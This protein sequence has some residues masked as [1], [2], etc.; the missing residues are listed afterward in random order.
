MPDGPSTGD[1]PLAGR[2]PASPTAV[3]T[4]AALLVALS[5]VLLGNADGLHAWFA[6]DDFLWLELSSL[7]SV[8]RSFV[9]PWGHGPA[10]RP[11]SRV[12][13]YA[14]Y[15][16]FGLDAGPWHL[17]SLLWHAAATTLLA[18]LLARTTGDAR[19][20]LVAA[21]IFAVLPLHY[22]NT[23]WISAR[24]HPIALM[25]SLGSLLAVESHLRSG[26]RRSLATAAALLALALLTYEAPI[27]TLPLALLVVSVRLRSGAHG[28]VWRRAALAL[29]VLATVVVLYLAARHRVLAGANLYAA[30]LTRSDAFTRFGARYV[31]AG[32]QMLDQ[33]WPSPW[34]FAAAGVV[35]CLVRRR[36]IP[37]ALAGGVVIAFGYAPFSPVENVAPRFLYAA[38]AGLAMVLAAAIAGLA[39]LPRI[40]RA[41]AALLFALLLVHE[42]RATRQIAR[43]FRDAGDLGRRTLARLA[44]AWPAPDPDRP[45]VVLGVPTGLGHAMI[46]FTYF[47]LALGTFHPAHAGMRVPGHVLTDFPPAMSHAIA[48]DTWRREQERR[49]RHGLTPLRCPGRQPDVTHDVDDFLRTLVAC[50]A[51]FYSIGPGLVPRRMM[52]TYVDARIARGW[53]KTAG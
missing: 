35:A 50:D 43:E 23:L 34:W 41:G 29:G 1:A 42:V 40:G 48:I 14:D 18:L 28:V 37:I 25:L 8:L 45:A 19:F 15:V 11:L 7:D 38:Q 36:T 52:Q 49:Q 31:E 53:R 27:Y 39:R 20:A 12:S 26:S 21:A 6:A 13:F 24:S 2:A 4:I 51:V 32:R 30:D 3:F 22:E 17:V 33:V 16:L 44:D 46:F 47:D 10:W 5:L 9:A